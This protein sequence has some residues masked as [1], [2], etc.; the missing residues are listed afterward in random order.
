MFLLS[1]AKIVNID[2]VG[3]DNGKGNGKK[4]LRLLLDIQGA[5][6]KAMGFFMGERAEE[7]SAGG[8]I[9]ILFNFAIDEWNGNRELMLRVV[10]F[11]VNK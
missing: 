4:H 7:L 5:K 1:D 10:D 6:R 2:R 8:S 9:D 11:R 3:K